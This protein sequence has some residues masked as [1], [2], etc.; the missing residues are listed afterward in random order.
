M[1]NVVEFPARHDDSI[2]EIWRQ[3][4]GRFTVTHFELGHSVRDAF[5]DDF[6]AAKQV[7]ER[8]V[9]QFEIQ[10]P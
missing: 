8:V 5:F 1:T 3:N 7:A 9:S 6:A 2:V 4:N 10:R